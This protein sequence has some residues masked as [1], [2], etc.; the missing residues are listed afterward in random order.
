MSLVRVPLWSCTTCSK[1]FSRKGDLTRHK[2]LH[3]GIKPHVCETCGKGFAQFSGLK[4]H[5]NV[6]YG[7]KINYFRVV[8][9]ERVSSKA[10]PYICGIGTCT[11]AFGDPSSRTRHRKETHRREGAYKC[12][13][14]DCGTRIKRRSAFVAHLR[15]HGLD[16][17]SLDLDAIVLQSSGRGIPVPA[18]FTSSVVENK[19]HHKVESRSASPPFLGD[20][21]YYT[22]GDSSDASYFMD[23]NGWSDDDL[24]LDRRRANWSPANDA[25]LLG[26]ILDQTVN[27]GPSGLPRDIYPYLSRDFKNPF[28]FDGALPATADYPLLVASPL[29]LS[30]L[31]PFLVAGS[32]GSQSSS[33]SPASTYSALHATD[34]NDDVVSLSLANNARSQESLLYIM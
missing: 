13:V 33:S 20:S 6:Q 22:F 2:S 26:S 30:V 19:T 10:K 24:L 15:K 31:E 11:K 27:V 34:F 16:P 9:T 8:L 32:D 29:N 1:S 4:T 7:I 14:T 21:L 12:I 23:N 5:R 25:L 17:N 18:H 28:C 3:T